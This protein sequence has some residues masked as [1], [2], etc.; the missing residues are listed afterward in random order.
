MS[1][2]AAESFV[3]HAATDRRVRAALAARTVQQL[4][5]RR[6]FGIPG[7]WIGSVAFPHPT[8]FSNAWHY[9]WQAHLLDALVDAA[10]RQ[11]ETGQDSEATRKRAHQLLRAVTL[12]SGGRVVFNNYYDDMSWLML[13]LGR[14]RDLEESVGGDTKRVTTAGARLLKD[15]RAAHTTDLDGGMF[16][17]RER[18]YKNTA[19]TGPAALIACRTSAPQESA[20][21]LTWLREKLWDPEKCVF[22]DGLNIITTDDGKPGTKLEKAVY[23]YNSGPA[24]GAAVELAEGSEGEEGAE[25]AAFGAEIVAGADREFGRDAGDRRVLRTHGSGDAGLFTGILARYLAEAAES[26]ALDENTRRT[27]RRL[28][29]DTADAL[30]E[31]R[32]EFDPELDFNDPQARPD[33]E[34]MQVIFSPDPLKHAN[35]AQPAGKTVELGTQIQAWTTLEA[36]AR[37]D[38]IV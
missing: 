10:H 14:L 5:G 2:D 28:V 15:I 37:L 26:P 13:A 33:P 6:L 24:L 34:R 1:Q 20:N 9:W 19:T 11:E 29:L 18:K 22:H 16:W 38:P 12:R 21:L 30:W 32:R 36:A 8:Q 17:T 27:A 31:G 23:S 7:T 25:W 35:E 4:F 3:P